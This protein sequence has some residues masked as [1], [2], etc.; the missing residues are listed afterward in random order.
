MK[1]MIL[2]VA[3]VS[4]ASVTAASA[5]T[6]RQAKALEQYV[7]TGKRETCIPI[8]AIRSTKIL[9]STSILFQ[10]HGGAVYL[11]E[12]P[13]PCGVLNPYRTI[14]YATS[15]E[16]VCNTDLITVLDAGS[17]VPKLGTCG[18]GQFEVLAEKPAGKTAN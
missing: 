1:R 11:N 9:D 16:K 17:S 13:Q 18:L 10:M 5:Q 12:L 14:A 3:L 2:A 7:R 4:C 15:I 6:E 8:N